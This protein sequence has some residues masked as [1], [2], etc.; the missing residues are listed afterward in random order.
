MKIKQN[1]KLAKYT[2]FQIGGPARYFGI[3]KTHED[4]KQAVDLVK[5]EKLPMLV[6]GGGSNMLISDKGFPGLA[7]TVDFLGWEAKELKNEVLLTVKSGEEWDKVVQICVKKGWWG[8]ENLSHI[9]GKT[10]AIAVQNVGAY[11]QDASQVVEKVTV[12]EKQSGQIFGIDKFSC[13]FSYRKSIFNTSRKNHFVILSTTF[14]LSKVPKPNL[15]YKDLNQKFLGQK[16]SLKE[17]REAVIEIRDKKYPF[18]ETA[19][20]GN[21]GSFFKNLVIKKEDFGKV[22]LKVQKS[23]GKDVSQKLEARAILI[24]DTFKIPSAFLL[25]ICG[26]KDLKNGGAKINKNQPLVILNYSGKAT[27]KDVLGLA[28]KVL[29][30]VFEKTGLWLNVEPELVGFSEKELADIVKK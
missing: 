19:K 28:K 27:S 24:K 8:I 13:N 3:A 14:R 20:N 25:E 21:A 1:E 22:L 4:L 16:P 26:L 29:Q 15:W 7:I 17:I 11:G 2:T 18:P 5:K 30:T 12:F 23:L 10:G 9:P 6:L